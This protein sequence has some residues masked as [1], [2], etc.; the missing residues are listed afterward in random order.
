[1]KAKR[2][3]LVWLLI[4]AVLLSFSA[5]S[6][7]ERGDAIKKATQE[8]TVKAK[9]VQAVIKDF[10]ASSF[11]EQCAK[12]L[13]KVKKDPRSWG[14]QV[15]VC[16][17]LMAWANKL[18]DSFE[19][20]KGADLTTRRDM[21]VKT[22]RTISEIKEAEAQKYQNRANEAKGA[23]KTRYEQFSAACLNFSKGYL[24]HAENYE[25]IPI[26]EQMIE[27]QL[28]IEYLD[29]AKEVIG[30]LREYLVVVGENDETLQQLLVA[31]QGIAAIHSSIVTFSEEVING[32]IRAGEG[33]INISE[34]GEKSVG[35][36]KK[37][38]TEQPKPTEQPTQK[39]KEKSGAEKK[40]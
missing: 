31:H 26:T 18:Y 39:P 38:P 23:W 9:E 16:D 25:K 21:V 28:C 24:L 37:A 5:V 40:A 29:S 15:E 20:A 7:S 13:E 8:L 27:V 3:T 34:T 17:I 2:L 19:K 1:M 6:A 30:G 14:S 35:Q 12:S 22:L 36:P 32:A 33:F 11:D 4:M 10:I